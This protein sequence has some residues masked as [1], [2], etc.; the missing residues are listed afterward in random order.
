VNVADVNTGSCIVVHVVASEMGMRIPLPDCWRFDDEG[1]QGPSRIEL[2]AA[3]FAK[4]CPWLRGS[5]PHA[6][7]QVDHDPGDG[8]LHIRLLSTYGAVTPNPLTRY[9]LWQIKLDHR[10]SDMVDPV[11]ADS[12]AGGQQ[13]VYFETLADPG[14]YP[15]LITAAGE[16]SFVEEYPGSS[17]LGLNYSNLPT[18]AFSWGRL[19]SLYR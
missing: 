12:C 14:W 15:V 8:S 5:T 2:K 19:K 11:E 18:R 3:S 4:S 10:V 17:F 6:I 7:V 9:T 16:E 1:C 13:R